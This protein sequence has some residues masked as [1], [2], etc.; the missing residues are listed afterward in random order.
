LHRLLTLALISSA[1]FLAAAPFAFEPNRG[2]SPTQA[3]WIARGPSY[4]LLLTDEGLTMMIHD[5]KSRTRSSAVRMK[6]EG[7]RPWKTL[8]GLEPTGG[9]AHTPRYAKVRAAGVYDGIDLVFHDHD[10]NL[11]Y[12]F[13]VAPGADPSNILLAFEGLQRMRIDNQSGELILTTWG[14]SELRHACPK[15]YQ[16]IGEKRVEIAGGYELLNSNRAAFTLARYDSRYPL[17]IY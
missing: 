8:T 12:D 15:V 17:A 9:Q 3:K 2:Q 6:L 7:S 10:G 14:G 13:V 1:S 4:D 16:Q 5:G 11:E